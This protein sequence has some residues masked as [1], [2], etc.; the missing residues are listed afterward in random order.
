MIRFILYQLVTAALFLAGASVAHSQVPNRSPSLLV[1]ELF[2]S[3]GCSS[4][5]AADAVFKTYAARTDI[6]ALSMSVDYWDYLGW[7]D[8][9]ASPKFSKR[10]RAYAKARADGQVYTPQAI[11]NGRDHIVGSSKSE[12]ES[13]LKASA[14]RPQTITLSAALDHGTVTIDIA[15]SNNVAS[16]ITVW[17]AIVQAEAHI[18]VKAGENRGRKL[19]YFNVVRDI[20][21]AG[22]WSGP[23]TIIRQP[24]SALATDANQRFAV[25]LQQGIGGPIVAATWVD[26]AAN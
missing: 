24:S 5:P 14:G 22:M 2:T 7:K 10:Q 1:L 4:C 11:V 26:P 9:F 12:I 6:V 23:A 20:V 18:N 3:Q 13:A 15:Q 17:L 19:T 21:P 25:L 16:E 8:T